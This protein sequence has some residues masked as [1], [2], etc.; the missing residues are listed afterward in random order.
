M[1]EQRDDE[2]LAEAAKRLFDESVEQLDAATLSRL[3]KGRH[4]ALAELQRAN[5][6]RHWLRWMPATGIVAA[7]LVTVMLMRGPESTVGPDVA[8]TVTDF[9]ILL[10]EE[11]LEMLEELEFFSWIDAADLDTSGNVG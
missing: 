5:S 10:D 9:E 6:A 1:H 11:S 2:R 3:N 7:A 8:V 4:D